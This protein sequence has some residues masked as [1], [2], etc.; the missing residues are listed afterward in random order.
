MIDEI[1]SNVKE[2]MDSTEESL[3][4]DL[5]KVRAGRA[6]P[7]LLDGIKVDYYGV[8][9]QLNKLATVSPPELR[10]LVVHPFDVSSSSAI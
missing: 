5:A 4:R 9:T 10:L 6:A 7:S 8:E 1:L 3:K 2:E